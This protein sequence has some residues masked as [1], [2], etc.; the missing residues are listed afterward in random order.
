MKK[1]KSFILKVE[2]TIELGVNDVV[3][4]LL[5]KLFKDRTFPNLNLT[6]YDTLLFPDVNPAN[7]NQFYTLTQT[8]MYEG[9][10][11]LSEALE[12]KNELKPVDRKDPLVDEKLAVNNF[13]TILMEQLTVKVIELCEEAED[14]DNKAFFDEHGVLW[15]ITFPESK[16][17]VPFATNVDDF[18]EL[19]LPNLIDLNT[20]EVM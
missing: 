3:E 4:E 11:E 14:Y 2:I 17:G 13:F 7:E 18:V 19:D 9:G 15:S 8:I 6:V 16:F 12:F 5:K 1:I 20:D 10:D